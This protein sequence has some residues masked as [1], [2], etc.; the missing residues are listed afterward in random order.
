MC[1][2][3]LANMT[4]TL[5][6]ITD[7]NRKF[8]LLVYWK[9]VTVYPEKIAALFPQISISKLRSKVTS[10]V[11]TANPANG[12]KYLKGEQRHGPSICNIPLFLTDFVVNNVCDTNRATHTLDSQHTPKA[13]HRHASCVWCV[14][15]T[16]ILDFG[17]VQLHVLS[18]CRNQGIAQL[19]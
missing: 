11:Q 1:K 3:W 7:I 2:I 15:H 14:I 8:S 17:E 13:T 9:E 12:W 19:Q 5:L 4:D 18:W 10:Q 16:Y 6:E